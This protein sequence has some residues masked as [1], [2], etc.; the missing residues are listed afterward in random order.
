MKITCGKREDILKRKEEYETDRAARKGR[1]DAQMVELQKARNNVMKPVQ[2]EIASKLAQFKALEFNVDVRE[3]RYGES[4]LSVRIQCNEYKK[5]NEDSAL[6]W[7]YDATIGRDGQI[8]KE[9]SSWSGLQAVTEVQMESLRSTLAAL[10][11]LNSVDWSELLNRKLPEYGDY[12]TERNPDWEG[13]PDFDRQLLEVDI[14]ECIGKNILIKGTH[15]NGRGAACYLITKETPKQYEVVEISEFYIE[16]TDDV[17][18]LVEQNRKY[19]QRVTKDKFMSVIK[20]PLETM[21]V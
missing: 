14:E 20:K 2:D 15:L 7:S 13:R 19:P 11:Y 17:A 21:E 16:R 18:A 8:L 1:Y 10:E 6:S 3:A 12:V 5:F 4:G 9:T